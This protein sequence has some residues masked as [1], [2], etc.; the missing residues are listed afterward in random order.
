MELAD[1]M[2]LYET[3]G[4]GQRLIPSLPVCIRLDGKAFHS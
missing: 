2:K 4:A 3:I 1:R